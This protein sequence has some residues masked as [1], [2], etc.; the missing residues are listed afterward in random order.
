[1][2]PKPKLEKYFENEN[3]KKCFKYK[4]MFQKQKIKKMFRK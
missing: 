1:M 2:F 4:K 3:S